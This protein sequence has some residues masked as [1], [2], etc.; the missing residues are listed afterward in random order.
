[1]TGAGPSKVYEKTSP[2]KVGNYLFAS[3]RAAAVTVAGGSP[4]SLAVSR[5]AVQGVG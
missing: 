2:A 3:S 4:P 5:A 1:M